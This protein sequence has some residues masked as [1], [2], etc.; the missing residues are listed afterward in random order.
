MADA[1]GP[2]ILL[3]L[4]DMAAAE[5]FAGA[6]RAVCAVAIV[7]GGS[8]PGGERERDGRT[9][10]TPHVRNPIERREAR[11]YMR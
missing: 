5:A 6:D 9:M 1:G 4:E 8:G 2:V 3:A 11:R 10:S 7:S